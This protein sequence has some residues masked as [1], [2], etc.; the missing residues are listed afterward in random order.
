[1]SRARGIVS[2]LNS[3]ADMPELCISHNANQKKLIEF[4][5][6]WHKI[7]PCSRKY[8]AIKNTLDFAS[9]SSGRHTIVNNA[10]RDFS[11]CWAELPANKKAR[12]AASKDN[13]QR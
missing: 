4:W 2:H 1:M 11:L 3:V 6:A 10:L 12:L 9:L 13:T 7:W 8:K 5:I